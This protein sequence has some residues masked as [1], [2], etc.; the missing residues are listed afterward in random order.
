MKKI[1]QHLH[2]MVGGKEVAVH[3]SAIVKLQASGNYTFIFTNNRRFVM[4]GTLEKALLIIDDAMFVRIH[5]S[6]VVNRHMVL[7][8]DR[9][10][11]NIILSHGEP[12][13]ISRRRKAAVIE[14][15]GKA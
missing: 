15:I 4:I 14:M 13:P 9:R 3:I 2:I 11:E 5:R 7:S 1:G 12:L 6:Y 8:M 10:K